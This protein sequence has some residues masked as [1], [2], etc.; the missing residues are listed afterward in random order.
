MRKL[1][2]LACGKVTPERQPP[3]SPRHQTCRKAA[4]SA[5]AVPVLTDDVEVITADL[6][7]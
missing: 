3:S 2:V 1:T 6:P 7:L 5:D 4:R